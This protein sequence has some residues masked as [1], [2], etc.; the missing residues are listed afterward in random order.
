MIKIKIKYIS[1]RKIFVLILIGLISVSTLF[2]QNNVV[3]LSL[4]DAIRMAVE[5]NTNVKTAQIEKQKTQS[6]IDETYSVLFPKISVG[7]SFTDNLKMPVM[8]LPGEIFQQPGTFIPVSFGTKYSA[9]AAANLNMILY[10]QSAMTA[11]K[12]SKKAAE[13]N[14]FAIEKIREELAFEVSKLYFMTLTTAEQKN[15]LSANIV[16]TQ[17]LRDIIRVLVDNG[18][19]LQVDLDRVNVNIENLQTQ[20]S[21]VEA[22]LEQQLNMLKY[23]LN[24]PLQNEIILTD[25]TELTL[26]AS[27]PTMKTD[28]TDH[29]DIRLLE[30]QK[31][32]NVLVKKITNAG[33][34]PSLY[35]TGQYAFQGMRNEFANYFKDSPENKWYASANI[36]LSLSI[37]IFDGFEKR[38]KANQSQLDILK[39]EALLLDKKESFNVNFRVALNNYNNHK[40]N[41]E[42][43]KQ[44]IELATKV[45]DETT[46][47]YREGMASMSNLL[48]DE[49]SLSAAQSNYLTALYN[50]KESELKIMSLN[51]D[52]K[53]FIGE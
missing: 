27:T 31:E 51:G 37:P 35:L 21:N 25:N 53:K 50:F 42:R 44:N 16:K 7:A 30:S 23:I 49:M 11:L 36:G 14:D 24:I 28:F 12:L 45:Y 34:F 8:L 20:L 6:I 29:I 13:I 19:A 1:M 15:I 39:T 4:Q 5:R 47:K 48:Q 22:G 18:M 32:V 10:N 40:T 52:M 2:A 26:L 43:Q 46:L 3:R 17:Q 41:L 33:Y 9:G 38:S